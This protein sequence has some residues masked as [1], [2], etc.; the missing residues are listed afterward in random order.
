[1]SALTPA[2]AK[3]V[4]ASFSTSV[5]SNSVRSAR[6]RFG[7]RAEASFTRDESAADAVPA[8]S[9]ASSGTA[10]RTTIRT[11]LAIKRSPQAKFAP[12]S[13]S[14]RFIT[15]RHRRA[16][17]RADPP[18]RVQSALDIPQ[19]VALI[20]PTVSPPISRTFSRKR[21]NSGCGARHIRALLGWSIHPTDESGMLWRGDH[22]G[23][24]GT[25]PLATI[26]VRYRRVEID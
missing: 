18:R 3:S 13:Q 1:G 2:T 20:Q 11:S 19:G 15:R 4:R 14:A 26:T 16:Y 12:T 6:V 23:G 25:R 10:N 8:A 7:N 17:L 24:T 21:L 9:A 5:F 22:D